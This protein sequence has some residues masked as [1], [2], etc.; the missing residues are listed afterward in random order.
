MSLSRSTRTSGRRALLRLE[1]LESRWTPASVPFLTTQHTDVGIAYEGGEWDPHAHDEDNDIEF[2]LGGFVLFGTPAAQ[3]QRPAGAQWDFLGTAAGSNIWVLPQSQNAGVLYLG[4]AAE[5]VPSGTFAAYEPTDPR[6]AGQGANPYLQ[7]KLVSVEGPG[8]FALYQVSQT[9]T[10]V[11]WM[12]SGDGLTDTDSA[13]VIEGGHQHYN[14]AFTERGVYKITLQMSGFLDT[15]GNGT[16]EPGVDTF[17]QS[18]EA[19]YT[20]A[21]DPPNAAPVNTVPTAAL[22]TFI[23]TP[24]ALGAGL[25]VSDPDQPTDPVRVTLTSSTGTLELLGAEGTGTN[26][27]TLTGTLAEVN[28]ALPTVKFVPPT[29]FSGSATISITTNDQGYFYPDLNSDG[30]GDNF[31]TDTDSFSITVAGTNPNQP[32]TAGPLTLETEFNTPINGNVLTV[33]SDPNNDPLTAALVTAPATTAGTVTFNPNGTFT[34]T[35]ATDFSG[36]ATFTFTVSDGTFTTSPATVTIIV[37]DDPLTVPVGLTDLVTS[38]SNGTIRRY[39]L[40]NGSANESGAFQ[41]FGTFAGTVRSAVADVNGDG[42]A[43]FIYVTG[44]GG[45]GRVRIISGATNVDLLNGQTVD[46]FPGQDLTNIGLFVTAGDINGDGSA[47]IIVSPDEGGGPVVKMF[48]FASG[49]LTERRIFLGIDDGAFRGGARVALGNFDGVGNLDLAVA[50]GFGGGPRVAL[51]NGDNLMNGQAVGA[52]TKLMGDFFA[53]EPGLRNGV[54][55]AGG[56]VNADGRADLVLGAG[57]GGGPRVTV[58]NVA[59]LQG[60]V[61]LG[62]AS[63]LANFFA[64]DTNQRGGVRVSVK[65]LDGDTR[66]DVVAAT[67]DNS[68]P[69][70]VVFPG[71]NLP[72]SGQGT[73]TGGATLSPFSDPTLAAGVFVG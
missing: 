66:L 34:F 47:E 44:P 45:G 64:F 33:A 26:T 18:E 69:R 9:G 49:V 15:N 55:V 48:S 36:T 63:P 28:A 59:A 65:D 14:W 24:V 58:L 4:I 35:P 46:A 68:A 1:E 50:A 3:T 57:P 6:V 73:P 54:F 61:N 67:G 19:E 16:Y 5:E 40:V 10:P 32:P 20:F 7:T 8:E 29:G 13:F 42:V 21:I 71:G 30:F 37:Q 70:V 31:K 60:N 17:S 11:V 12:A 38:G 25:S 43:D 27:L 53:F 56:D 62:L 39:Q 2:E 23:S 72:P 51:Y 52:P 41:P 22:S